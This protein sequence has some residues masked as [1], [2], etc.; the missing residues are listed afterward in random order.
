MYD[1]YFTTPDIVKKSTDLDWAILFHIALGYI[2][3]SVFKISCFAFI[4]SQID[5]SARL[6]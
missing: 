5:Q 6:E 1:D 2:I 4:F 3:I